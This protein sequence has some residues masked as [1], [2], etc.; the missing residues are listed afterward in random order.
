MVVEVQWSV[1][2]SSDFYDWQEVWVRGYLYSN[3]G[4]VMW[5]PEPD[6]KAAYGEDLWD[7]QWD[8]LLAENTRISNLKKA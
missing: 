5:T 7:C 4:V 8:N 2:S 3:N 6:A 1:R